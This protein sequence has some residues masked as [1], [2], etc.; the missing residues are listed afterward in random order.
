ML[1]Q[2]LLSMAMTYCLLLDADAASQ[3]L[4]L[5]ANS[6]SLLFMYSLGGSSEQTVTASL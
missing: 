2:Q 3:E 6:Q 5:Q 4:S 1:L